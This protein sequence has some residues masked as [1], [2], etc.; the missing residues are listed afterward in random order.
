MDGRQM[1]Y[2]ILRKNDQ[3]GILPTAK[4]GDSGINKDHTSCDSPQLEPGHF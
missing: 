3:I 4:A 1:V 2:P